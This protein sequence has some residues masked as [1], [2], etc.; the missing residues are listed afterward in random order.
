MTEPN[1]AASANK[2][3]VVYVG[4]VVLISLPFYW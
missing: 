3:A 2:Q 1:A 4:L